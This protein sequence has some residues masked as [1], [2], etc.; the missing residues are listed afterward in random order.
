MSILNKIHFYGDELDLN[1][2][3]LDILHSETE[4]A[5]TEQYGTVKL[6]TDAWELTSAEGTVT[7]Q[8]ADTENFGLV[9][10]GKY[11][12]IDDDNALSLDLPVASSTVL[13]GIKI[14][15]TTSSTNFNYAVS[16][17]ENNNAYVNCP[18]Y[19]YLKL[20]TGK[21]YI[22]LSNSSSA[23]TGY[24][25]G[26]VGIDVSGLS[27]FAKYAQFLVQDSD[28]LTEKVYTDSS[29]NLQAHTLTLT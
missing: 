14:G 17:D 27:N 6:G 25:S 28:H 29:G 20:D 22:V 13:G 26:S 21:L 3:I 19:V 1:S 16:L 15:Y 23:P 9:K 4:K 5:T 2:Q 8:N 12:K 24:T 11:L 10:V 18:W 7:T